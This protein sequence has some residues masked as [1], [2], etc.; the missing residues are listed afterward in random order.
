MKNKWGSNSELLY[1][2][3]FFGQL[4]LCVIDFFFDLLPRLVHFG[5][6]LSPIQSFSL[7]PNYIP[8]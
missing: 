4:V 8:G 3:D 7:P 5:F 2:L 6:D 1:V